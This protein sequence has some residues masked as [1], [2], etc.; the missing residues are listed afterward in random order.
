L[1]GIFYRGVIPLGNGARGVE[2]LEL[3]VCHLPNLHQEQADKLTFG[4]HHGL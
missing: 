1:L 4:L 2:F 3:V